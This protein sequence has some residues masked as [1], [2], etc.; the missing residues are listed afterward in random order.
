[1]MSRT[2]KVAFSGMFIALSIVFTRFFSYMVVIG[3]AQTV[4]LSF[5]DLPLILSGIVLGPF[6]GGLTG[7]L[8][9]L[10]GFPFNPQGSYFPG[11]TLT[12]ALSGLLPG[13][14]GIL[15]K[16]KWS[17]MS[18]TIAIS[19]TMIITSLILNTYWLKMMM[20]Q[21]FAVLL[22]PRIIAVAFL[23]PVYIVVIKLILKHFHRMA[24]ASPLTEQ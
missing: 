22:P 16:R 10:I 12:A 7:A 1:M 17:W 2:K 18:L 3:G 9:D 4:R 8:A 15:L 21:A 5:G 23:M 11:F 13:L 6:Y 24:V 19:I 20:G 14:M